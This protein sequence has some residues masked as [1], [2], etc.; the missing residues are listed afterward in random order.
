[1][2]PLK[3]S[4]SRYL[5]G[6]DRSGGF[7]YFRFTHGTADIIKHRYRIGFIFCYLVLSGFFSRAEPGSNRELRYNIIQLSPDEGLSQGSNYFRFEDSRGFMWIT[8]NDALNRYDG[9]L[10]KVYNLDKYFKGCP[11]LQQGYGFAEDDESN[12]YIGSTRGIYIYHRSTDKFTL[13][14]IFGAGKDA[15]AMPFACRA[16]KIWC[17]NKRYEIATYS[18]ADHKVDYIGRVPLPEL[19]SVH[20]Y[21][22]IDDGF[23]ERWPFFDQ[24][25]TIWFPGR[26]AVFTLNT[27]TRLI[28]EINAF[29]EQKTKPVFHS[30]CYDKYHDRVLLGA[31]DGLWVYDI[32]AAQMHRIPRLGGTELDM[33]SAICCNDTMTVLKSRNGLLFTNWLFKDCF[34]MSHTLHTSERLYKLGFDKARRLWMC[35]DGLGQ[36]IYDFTPKRLSVFPEK[37]TS[38]QLRKR[39]T[40][41]APT[42]AVGSIAA[43]P[44]GQLLFDNGQLFDHRAR[45]MREI[46]YPVTITYRMTTD[47]YR[48]GIWTYGTI[49][50]D[51]NLYI[52][53]WNA[54]KKLMLKAVIR[55]PQGLGLCQYLCVLNDGRMLL[56]FSAGLF[57]LKGEKLV[58]VPVQPG[59]SPFVT[60]LISN[61]RCAI[62]YLNN[63][64]WIATYTHTDTIKFVQQILPGIQSFYMQ[65]DTLRKQYWVGTNKGIY[66]L[67]SRFETIHRFDANNGLAGTYIYG[68]LLDNEGNAWCSHQR[69]L[70][71]IDARTFQ[72]INYDENDGIQD[73]DFN[74]RA[75][76]KAGDGTLFFGGIR[77]L[78]YFRPPLMRTEYYEPEV[79]VD[80]IKVND[81]TYLPDT[82]ANL[83]DRI[84]LPFTENTIA[85]SAIVKDLGNG[86]SRKLI[87]RIAGAN[88]RWHHLSGNATITFNNL[89]PGSYTIELGI[90]DKY[91]QHELSQKKIMVRIALP[92]YRELWFGVLMAILATAI[93]F[94]IFNRRK[95]TRQKAALRQQQALE[96]QRSKIT[97]D[98]H[99]DIGASL[100]SLQVNST[101]A[102]Q[103]IHRNAVQAEVILGKIATQSRNLAEQ[104]DDL[105]WSMKTGSQQSMTISNR[106]AG[107]AYDMLGATDIQYQIRISKDI[108]VRVQDMTM[109]KNIVLI[110]K[111][112]INNAVKHSGASYISI[113]L[114]IKDDTL[115][116]VVADNGKGYTVTVTTGNGMT[117]MKKR[118]EEIGGTFSVQS[119]PLQGT[120]INVFIPVL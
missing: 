43:F 23:Y 35:N 30:S 75:F 13:Q 98:L 101:V 114:D 50:K 115:V 47:P 49:Y 84:R 46:F 74:N 2:L 73:W 44:D 29:G 112:A 71:S 63:D 25:N 57:W 45:T 39:D 31:E 81:R 34:W 52:F 59:G 94:W 9:N 11:N 42:F 62:S 104:I 26:N 69:G 72:I 55:E 105:I 80:E 103:L 85:I 77:G 16:G 70:S 67:N 120:S 106:I 14:Q 86:P 1:M 82:N 118:A 53:F 76:Y 100:S 38:V 60:N 102:G 51:H 56:S 7:Q 24:N 8:C 37:N 89:A 18:I 6:A 90:Y 40:G 99:D 48:K 108:D 93:V 36:I 19:S 12:I 107:Y 110:T 61:N 20:I 92:F 119:V 68:L 5:R 87:Y 22:L 64:M 3:C 78:N 109:K 15:L 32:R 54:D 88:N 21:N 33:V 58:R 79:Y 65:E 97:A 117:N 41:E 66:V 83:V 4:A 116:L 17:F 95:R 28:K 91:S 27:D 96:A 113:D 10:V 111:E